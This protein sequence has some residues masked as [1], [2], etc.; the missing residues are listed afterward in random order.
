MR[1]AARPPKPGPR[2]EKIR[3]IKRFLFLPKKIDNE[4]RWMEWAEIIQL[5]E[6]NDLDKFLEF[7]EQKEKFDKGQGSPPIPHEQDIP[8]MWKSMVRCSLGKRQRR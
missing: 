6:C 5:Y 7:C 3:T 1:V 8:R 2:G 4:W